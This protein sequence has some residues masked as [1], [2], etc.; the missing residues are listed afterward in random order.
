[1][2]IPFI[3]NFNFE[4]NTKI[5]TIMNG[6]FFSSL[7]QPG[8]LFREFLPTGAVSEA[9][10]I[11]YFKVTSVIAAGIVIAAVSIFHDRIP[12]SFRG[13]TFAQGR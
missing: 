10:H 9:R 7:G 2:E 13:T 4:V 12:S 6:V 8:P 1:M 3:S 5:T 11:D